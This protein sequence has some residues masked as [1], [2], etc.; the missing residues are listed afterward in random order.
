MKTAAKPGRDQQRGGE[1]AEQL[2][3]ARPHPLILPSS[4]SLI[5]L[6]ASVW[7]RIAWLSSVLRAIARDRGGR[8]AGDVV[9][10]VHRDSRTAARTGSRGTQRPCPARWFRGSRAAGWRGSRRRRP[11]TGRTGSP[12]AAA[13]VLP[14]APKCRSR[15]AGCTKPAGMCG[16]QPCS[17]ARLRLAGAGPGSP[18]H[19]AHEA[20]SGTDPMI[21]G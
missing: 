13:T 6:V 12:S 4:R 21:V 15:P 9:G 19:R 14:S 10:L 20:A 7:S 17:R 8:H 11:G 5:S 1:Q 16:L 18:S 3:V 2:A